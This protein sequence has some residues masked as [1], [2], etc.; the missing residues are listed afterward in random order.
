MKRLQNMYSTNS[1]WTLAR[2]GTQSERS[3]ELPAV[4]IE[5]RFRSISLVALS[6]FIRPLPGMSPNVH[7][8]I[9][10]RSKLS[11]TKRAFIRPLPGVGPD[12]PLQRVLL[13]EGTRTIRTAI[14]SLVRMHS[15]M[16]VIVKMYQM[17]ETAEGGNLQNKN[18]TARD[19]IFER[20]S[21]NISNQNNETHRQRVHVHT[22]A[23]A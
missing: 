6:A 23:H 22:M 20:I 17:F 3:M 10:F 9:T 2:C 16:S 12:V 11:R 19:L 21:E 14:W 18:K 8:Q 7:F 5:S 1:R 4:S 15:N 13:P